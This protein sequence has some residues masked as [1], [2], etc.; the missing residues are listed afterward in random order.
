MFQTT[1]CGD[2]PTKVRFRQPEV[3]LLGHHISAV[4]ISPSA[5]KIK[6]IQDFP[7]PNTMRQ[8]HAFQGLVNFYRRFLLNCA[9][10]HLPLTR[11]L[12]KVKKQQCNI[13]G[14]RDNNI[15][16][17]ERNAARYNQI[18]PHPTQPWI[19]PG[20]RCFSN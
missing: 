7:F 12:T 15:Q 17:S 1:W 20:G 10:V 2:Q 9:H 14:A 16:E 13:V 8:L 5:D 3:T 6:S 18:V 19:V 11:L 4:G